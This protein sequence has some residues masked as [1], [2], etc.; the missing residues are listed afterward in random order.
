MLI[1]PC[2]CSPA[3][4]HDSIKAVLLGKVVLCQCQTPPCQG[5]GARDL[6]QGHVR[7][8][9]PSM[10]SREAQ[11]LEAGTRGHSPRGS[12]S[13]PRRWQLCR[14]P[15]QQAQKHPP[16]ISRRSCSSRFPRGVFPAGCVLAS[17]QGTADVRALHALRMSENRTKHRKA[18][19]AKD[20]SLSS[21]GGEETVRS[22][23]ISSEM[24]C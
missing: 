1:Y 18:T 22:P 13:S 19:Q 10:P 3:G 5:S 16:A 11:G 7:T 6:Q 14:Y 17:P 2:P 4:D 23:A 12:R 20:K 21:E 15:R 24:L 9:P 8:F